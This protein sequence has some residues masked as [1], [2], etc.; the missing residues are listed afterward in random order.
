[1]PLSK[2]QGHKI[3]LSYSC[4]TKFCAIEHGPQWYQSASM[5]VVNMRRKISNLRNNFLSA[6]NMQKADRKVS[7]CISQ[8]SLGFAAVTNNS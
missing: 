5:V 8:I 1:M 2:K 7:V 4:F 3:E 6:S